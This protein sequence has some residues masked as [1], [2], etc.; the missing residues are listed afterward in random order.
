MSISVLTI[1]KSRLPALVN[2]LK[3]LEL[4]TTLPQELVV[5]HMNE[6]KSDLKSDLFAVRSF[7]LWS[8]VALPLAEARNFARQM[9]AS[10]NMIFIDVDCVPAG[11]LIRIYSESFL[12]S[13]KLW[14]GQVRYLKKSATQTPG[15]LE[16]LDALSTPDPVRSNIDQMSYELFWSLNFACNKKTYDRIGGFDLGFQ[17]YGAEDTDFSFSAREAGVPIESSMS[18]VYHQYHPSYD[19]PLNHFKDIVKNALR[20]YS[21]WK[22]WPMGGWLKKFEALELIRWEDDNITILRSPDEHEIQLALKV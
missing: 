6:K 7:E 12:A 20:F 19:P 8:D 5:V 14:A 22:H 10:E 17:G 9:S 18:V 16:K 4:N 21:K 3:G 13:N 2:L 11:N 1:V 15:F